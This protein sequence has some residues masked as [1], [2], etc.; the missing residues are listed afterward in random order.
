MIYLEDDDVYLVTYEK[1]CHPGGGIRAMDHWI[2]KIQGKNTK[3]DAIDFVER[4]KDPEWMGLHRN[5]KIWKREV[6]GIR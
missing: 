4:L 6:I 1:L 2:K 3:A 5:V